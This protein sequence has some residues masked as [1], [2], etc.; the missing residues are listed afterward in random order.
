MAEVMA[1][2]RDASFTRAFDDAAGVEAVALA[3]LLRQGQALG[4]FRAFDADEVAHLIGAA[5]NG[6]L[7]R[8]A[9]DEALDLASASATLLDFVESAVSFRSAMRISDPFD[10]LGR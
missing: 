8:W 5:K 6:V 7:D 10:E 3:E 1:N 4:Q 2:H 9:S